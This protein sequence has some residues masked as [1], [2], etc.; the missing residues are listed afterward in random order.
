MGQAARMERTEQPGKLRGTTRQA[1]GGQVA[2][3]SQVVAF[4]LSPGDSWPKRKIS[5]VHRKPSAGLYRTVRRE[6]HGGT[7][8]AD[9]IPTRGRESDRAGPERRIVPAIRRWAAFKP[10]CGQ[11]CRGR[12]R[13]RPV[14]A[15]VAHK[16]K[17]ECLP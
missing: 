2:E 17:T 13:V 7:P 9:G 14:M 3:V 6:K 8:A 5:E 1:F 4:F 16:T 11:P 15:E 10:A 12:S